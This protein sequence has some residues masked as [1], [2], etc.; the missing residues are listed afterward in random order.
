MEYRKL[1]R[2]NEMISVLGLGA[3]QLGDASEEEIITTYKLAL[4]NGI[5]FFDLCA[6]NKKLF[7]PFGKAIKGKRDKIYIQVHFGAVFNKDNEYGWSRNI[8]EIKDT[9]NYELTSIGTDYIDFG[10]LH[11]VD[12]MDDYEE[13]VNSGVLDYLKELK[14]KGI[15]RHIGFSSHT[16]SVANK[17]LDT[18]LVDLFMF[19]INAGYDYERGD[20]LGIGTTSER[21]DLFKRCEKEGIAISVMKPFLGG[22]L[23]DAKTSPFKVALTRYQCLAYCLDRPGVITLVPGVRNSSDLKELLGFFNATKEEKDYSLIASLD[24]DKVLGSCVYCNHCLPCPKGIDIGLVNKYYDLA[25]VGDKLAF[26]HYKKLK[27]KASSCI[28]CGH[29]NSRCPFKVKQM[30]KMTKIAKYFDE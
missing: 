18:G 25:L 5:N 28:K 19:S 26:D 23:L 4:D 13:L 6:G 11:C 21:L 7:V 22:K 10:F 1:P 27:I 15:V 8:K 17:I 16:P 20:E 29:C 14:R 2:G 3:G 24:I 30:E 12:E 9:V